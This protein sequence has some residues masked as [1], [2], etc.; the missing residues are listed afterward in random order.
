[1]PDEESIKVPI[2]G[3][4]SGFDSKVEG[5]KGTISAASIAMG[6]LLADLGKKAISS[7][8]NMISSGDQ[9]NQAI[10]Q[11]SASTGAVGTELEGMREVVKDVYGNNFGESYEDAANAVAEVSRQTGL[12]GEELQKATEGAFLLSDTLEMDVQESTKAA[13]S[14]MSNF[15]ISAEEAYNLIAIGAQ[16]GADSSGEL[17]DTLNEYSA[18]CAE[19]GLSAQQFTSALV[20]GADSGVYSVDKIGDAIREMNTTV[21][22]GSAAE[23]LQALGFNADDMAAR[24]AA[25]GETAQ[26]AFSEVVTA[27][28]NTK[29]P[30]VR[31]NA[32]CALMGSIYEDTGDGIVT[33]LSAIT[34]TSVTATD[35]LGQM[36]EVKY[37][38]VGS[39]VEG[40]KRTIGK[41]TIDIRSNLSGGLADAIGGFVGVLQTAD[42]DTGKIFDGL[43]EAGKTALDAIAPVI[44]GWVDKGKE[45]IEKIVTGIQENLPA[46]KEKAKDILQMLITGIVN[47][48]DMIVEIGLPLLQSLIQGISENAPALLEAGQTL[49]TGIITA[50]TDAL[51]MLLPIAVQLI[52]MLINGIS[53]S[54]VLLTEYLPTIIEAIVNILI[55]NLPILIDAAI[56]IIMALINGLSENIPLLIDAVILLLNSLVEMLVENLPVLLDAAVQIL[57]ALITGIVDNL[58]T[59]IPA[60]VNMILAIVDALVDNL[61]DLIDA[62]LT[63]IMALVEGLLDNLPML[64]DAAI[65][66]VF[67]L[68]TGLIK[69]IPDLV[70]A[71]PKIISAIW[72]AITGVDWLELGKNILK[73]IADG[74]VDGV[75]AIWDTVQ[76]VAGDL[77]TGFKDFFGINSPSKLMRDTVG[78]FLLPGVAV[79]MEDTTGE[80]ADQ[81]NR[82]LDEVMNHLDTNRLQMRLDSAVQMQGYSG[83]NPITTAQYNA[84]K[85]TLSDDYRQKP[86][87]NNSNWTFPIYLTPNTQVLD[88]IVI[89]AKDRANAVSGGTEF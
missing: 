43:V 55:E 66:L 30:L 6:N 63:L 56:A 78:K 8:G 36:N 69:A 15:G 72:D 42:G 26:Q 75:S 2:D 54:L 53:E 25:G 34:D 13:K 82:S 10:N 81:L 60:A 14:M 59:L 70:K 19:A 67:G 45:I 24:F 20:A 71:I 23:G 21:K 88:T 38:D 85:Q 48:V 1:M 57:D 27:L 41:A 32:A 35:A 73:G 37:D 11:L 22:D 52:V 49:L 80:T 79:G 33:A 46:I 7:F 3:D 40:L 12:M 86:S 39:A 31:N 4:T 65:K 89:T 58:D 61:P 77:W 5:M 51:P 29:D 9:F 50:I 68:I 84:Q 18:D 44:E 74:L 17:I 47:K 83:L 16:N 64:I 28:N 76:D 62:A 87:G